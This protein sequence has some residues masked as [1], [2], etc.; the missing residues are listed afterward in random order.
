MFVAFLALIQKGKWYYLLVPPTRRR[1]TEAGRGDFPEI[2]DADIFK[3]ASETMSILEPPIPIPKKR[4]FSVAE[5]F[6]LSGERLVVLNRQVKFVRVAIYWTVMACLMYAYIG[7][8]VPWQS[9]HQLV[10]M[11]A[12]AYGCVVCR[13]VCTAYHDCC[14]CVPVDDRIPCG[15]HPC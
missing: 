7:E 10:P 6:P 12:A 4:K 14:V 9:L 1:K 2:A 8:K 3:D 15:V 5:L 11:I 13:D